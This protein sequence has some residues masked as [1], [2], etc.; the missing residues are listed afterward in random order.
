MTTYLCVAVLNDIPVISFLLDEVH[1]IELDYP[2]GRDFSRG[3][4]LMR[5]WLT[6]TLF[7]YSLRIGGTLHCSRLRVCQGETVAQ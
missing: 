1:L 6:L 3:R 7:L 2:R 4:I 5:P